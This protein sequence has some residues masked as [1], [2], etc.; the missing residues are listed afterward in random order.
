MA[1][2]PASSIDLTASPREP[3][4]ETSCRW[5]AR[6]TVRDRDN[7]SYTSNTAETGNWSFPASGYQAYLTPGSNWDVLDFDYR[8]LEFSATLNA[9][10][11]E[12]DPG[13]V[14]G[15]MALVTGALG[16]LERRLRRRAGVTRPVTG[17]AWG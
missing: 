8:K 6:S 4:P 12:L 15:V 2:A 17:P 10:V 1:G 7:R 9:S 3:P 13:S 5:R 11:P 16:C 14:G